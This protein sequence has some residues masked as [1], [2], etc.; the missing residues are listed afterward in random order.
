MKN[1]LLFT[2][3]L[4]AGLHATRSNAA[5]TREDY[6]REKRAK[7]E[8]AA[9]RTPERPPRQRQLDRTPDENNP[10]IM[11]QDVQDRLSDKIIA[12]KTIVYPQVEAVYRDL[13]TLRDNICLMNKQ[14][15]KVLDIPNIKAIIASLDDSLKAKVYSMIDNIGKLESDY[16]QIYDDLLETV[17]DIDEDTLIELVEVQNLAKYVTKK[18]QAIASL[19]GIICETDKILN[20][21]GPEIT[22]KAIKVEERGRIKHF[23]QLT[24]ITNR[25]FAAIE[26]L[27]KR[28]EVKMDNSTLHCKEQTAQLLKKVMILKHELIDF[29]K[30]LQHQKGLLRGPTDHDRIVRDIAGQFT[31]LSLTRNTCEKELKS[32]TDSSKAQ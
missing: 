12:E 10:R 15:D 23:Q 1:L 29:D 13:L 20:H 17:R 31:K 18:K 7:Q 8:N 9:L 5:Q 2:I 21:I 11:R 30:N 14:V 27:L 4:V 26:N 6:E 22:G 3:A 24:N 25:L 32:I 19:K 28:I 16:K